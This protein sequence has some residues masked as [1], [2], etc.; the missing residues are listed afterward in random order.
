MQFIVRNLSA[1]NCRCV[2]RL[3]LTVINWRQHQQLVQ[4]NQNVESDIVG[5]DKSGIGV[6]IGLFVGSSHGQ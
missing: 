2:L 1:S 4:E 5:F 6:F 3:I